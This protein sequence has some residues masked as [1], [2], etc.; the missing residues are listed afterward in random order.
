MKNILSEMFPT[1]Y[2]KVTDLERVGNTNFLY[3]GL[4]L[5]YGLEGSGK[6]WQIV[7]SDFGSNEVLYLDTDGANGSMFV[8]HCE[9]HNVHYVDS[10]TIMNLNKAFIDNYNEQRDKNYKHDKLTTFQKV[11]MLLVSLVDRYKAVHGES[12]KP[13]FIID[14]FSSMSEGA[15]INNSEDISYLLY[16]FSRV[17]EELNICLI[18][19]DHATRNSERDHKFKLEG[20]E[21]GKK[22][23][24][25][26]V[27]KYLQNDPNKP[28]LGGSFLCE[29][30][31]GNLSGLK[32]GDLAKVSSV[33][34]S[35]ALDW[36]KDRFPEALEGEISKSDF[37]K[38]TK[39]EK[40][41]WVKDFIDE[42]FT[43]RFEGKGTHKKELYKLRGKFLN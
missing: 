25:V 10:N 4:N 37:T 34:V 6:S 42:L 27:N 5:V 7:A 36:L 8:E 20:N 9:N 26:T 15:K 33:N 17:A 13:I 19:I 40:D 41:R 38:K 29:R 31:R 22:R 32:I 2:G 30:A 35:N 16:Q 12:V 21:G 43:K 11:F 24:T 3:G 1:G 18:L 14:S 28:E 23:T 39:N